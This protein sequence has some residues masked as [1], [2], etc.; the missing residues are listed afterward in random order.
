MPWYSQTIDFLFLQIHSDPIH[1]DP[2]VD[3]LC[4]I[5]DGSPTRLLLVD[6]SWPFTAG[7]VQPPADILAL[8]QLSISDVQLWRNSQLSP[9]EPF[10]L[11]LGY[12]PCYVA[13][14]RDWPDSYSSTV[15]HCAAIIF[16]QIYNFTSTCLNQTTH[17]RI[18]LL[19]L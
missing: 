11:H 14:C 9:R 18:V 12:S 13:S 6:S 8:F 5:V 10:L 1:S 3:K 17:N 2:V 16:G 4:W 15:S 19:K 7:S